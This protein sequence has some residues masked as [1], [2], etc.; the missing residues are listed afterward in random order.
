V[1]QV[2]AKVAR[3]T[4][5]ATDIVG[6]LGGEEFAALLLSTAPEAAVAAERVRAALAATPI[7]SNGGSIAATV[8]IGVASGSPTT[9]IDVLIAR[10]DDALYRAKKNGRNRVEIAAGPVDATATS[11]DHA[12]ALAQAKAQVQAPASVRRRNDEGAVIDGAPES[13]VA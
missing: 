5:R 7:V 12:Q 9:A 1:L 8:S 3:D 11:P 6:R 10:A 13:C 4:L 2:F